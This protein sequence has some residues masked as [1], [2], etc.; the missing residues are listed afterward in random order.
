MAN[1]G[2]IMSPRTHDNQ[3]GHD[4]GRDATK[5][6]AKKDYCS[7]VLTIY[8]DIRDITLGTSVVPGESPGFEAPTGGPPGGG[9]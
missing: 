4:D 8:G 2:E 1:N 5:V 6:V 7:P 9:G 3:I